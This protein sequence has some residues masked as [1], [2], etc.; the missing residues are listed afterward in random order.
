MLRVLNFILPKSIDS[1][2]NYM[3]RKK[4]NKR[5]AKPA[6]KTVAKKQMTTRAP[7]ANKAPKTAKAGISLSDLISMPHQLSAQ[8]N[9]DLAA[10]GQQQKK[11]KSSMIKLSAQIK[12]SEK[13]MKAASK[14]KTATGKK[15]AMILK[16]AH[17]D[18]M[19]QEIALT[20][21]LKTAGS[22]LADLNMQQK[23]LAALAKHM[24]QFEKEWA[25]QEKQMKAKEK[26]K[27]KAKV[28]A[29]KAKRQSKKAAPMQPVQE[30]M[31]A[32]NVENM[33]MTNLEINETT[34]YTS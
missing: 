5:S 2:G 31:P 28:K 29:K 9:K 10:C 8:V 12:A 23:K 20:K 33:E 6:A 24:S 11:I 16:K 21:D 15:Q 14:I 32:E 18:L 25:K 17:A 27:A 13:R 22:D 3:S 19:K 4:T 7:K 30:M 34:D 1:E 26:A